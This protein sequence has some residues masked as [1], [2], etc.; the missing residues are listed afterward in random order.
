MNAEMLFI[1][2]FVIGWKVDKKITDILAII[3]PKQERLTTLE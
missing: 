2:L 1:V 3:L